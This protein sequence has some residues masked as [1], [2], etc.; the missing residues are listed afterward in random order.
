MMKKSITDAHD[1]SASHLLS[2]FLP[3]AAIDLPA[4]M[5]SL[6]IA[7]LLTP[8][9]YSEPFHQTQGWIF[10]PMAALIYFSAFWARGVYRRMWSRAGASEIIILAESSILGLCGLFLINLFLDSPI[11]RSFGELL[12]GFTLVFAESIVLRYRMRVVRALKWHH[13]AVH[14]RRQTAPEINALIVGAGRVAD[15]FVRAIQAYDGEPNYRIIGFVDDDERKSGMLLHGKPILGNR[16]DIPAL[17][18]GNRVNVVILAMGSIPGPDMRDILAICQKTD[19]LIRITPDIYDLMTEDNKRPLVREIAVEDL[20]GRNPV[21]CDDE[22]SRKLV[23][24]ASVA[25]TGAAGS[26]GSHLCRY[27]L[28]FQPKRLILIDINEA[29]VCKVRACARV[30]RYK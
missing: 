18:S 9:D 6:G 29:G 17:V 20:L 4:I 12:L 23:Q 28:R 22:S 24:G 21:K 19:A 3:W 10:I 8:M 30:V 1:S 15:D 14:M 13:H 5:I 27:I 11:R 16:Y 2:Y 26:I 25:V 7:T